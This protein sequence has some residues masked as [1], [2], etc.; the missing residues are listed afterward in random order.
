MR[1]NPIPDSWRPKPGSVSFHGDGRNENLDGE[2][3]RSADLSG[4]D[5]SGSSFRNAD[6]SGAILTNCNLDDCDF[7]GANL[8]RARLD[9]VSVNGAV[10]AGCSVK[11]AV[12]F[13]PVK[14]LTQTAE[15]SPIG[16]EYIA[17]F[18]IDPNVKLPAEFAAL[19]N[20]RRGE[21]LPQYL[22]LI[23]S[24]APADFNIP[25]ARPFIYTVSAVRRDARQK[26]HNSD[27]SYIAYI[28]NLPSNFDFSMAD[29][30]GVDFGDV[31]LSTANF[32]YASLRRANL[33]SADIQSADFSYVTFEDIS[34]EENRYMGTYHQVFERSDLNRV[35]SPLQ[36]RRIGTSSGLK[37]F[38]KCE[39]PEGCSYDYLA[40]SDENL[41]SA[42]VDESGVATA[43]VCRTD[44][45]LWYCD[46]CGNDVVLYYD[47]DY[48]G[49]FCVHCGAEM[50]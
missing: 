16:S 29:L 25:D 46:E 12:L 38:H 26:E 22:E 36:L 42:L 3:L 20:L 44:G 15:F 35:F 27:R 7:T 39:N 18:S 19:D 14:I 41:F 34:P 2:D 43:Y 31:D 6:L 47:E 40:T 10:F 11:G 1:K 23:M 32:K 4:S 5:L 49:S 8:D 9:F 37:G 21:Y 48:G 50:D 30:R 33:K 24:L 13:D 28:E 17:A 45:C